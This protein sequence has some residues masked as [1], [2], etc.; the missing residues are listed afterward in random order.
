MAEISGPER[1]PVR[2]D[3]AEILPVAV[4]E[5][6]VTRSESELRAMWH[7][8]QET[9]I[10]AESAEQRLK[11]NRVAAVFDDVFERDVLTYVSR[12]LG[13]ET[14][15]RASVAAP[16]RALIPPPWSNGHSSPVE[17]APP[18]PPPAA[19]VPSAP[20]GSPPPPPP[21]PSTPGVG[22]TDGPPAAPPRSPPPSSAKPRTVV[23]D[24]SHRAAEPTIGT[25]PPTASSAPV[26]IDPGTPLPTWS[27]SPALGDA[28]GG[29]AGAIAIPAPEHTWT[30]RI[31]ARLLMQVGLVLVVAALLLLKLG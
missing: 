29:S 6:L 2:P 12:V 21:V 23:V 22:S 8:L 4:V 15:E 26:V 3:L 1:S 31:P 10:A 30:S 25:S 19:A 7:E 20:L 27:V 11:A 14:A 5:A 24:R 13:P 17:G 9:V 28:H 18:P 16:D